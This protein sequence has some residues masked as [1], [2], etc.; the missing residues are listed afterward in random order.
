MATFVAL[1]FVWAAVCSVE[2]L[3]D[4]EFDEEIVEELGDDFVPFGA[5]SAKTKKRKNKLDRSK[6]RKN[7]RLGGKIPEPM[8]VCGHCGEDDNFCLKCDECV[9]CSHSPGQC[10]PEDD[11]ED[12]CGNNC[13]G[14]ETGSCD[15]YVCT[16]GPL[17][18]K[19]GERI[20]FRQQMRQIG[21]LDLFS[22]GT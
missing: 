13:P 21:L 14:V 1:M 12:N 18:G 3:K 20:R 15:E 11:F 4:D 19:A 22:R 9:C 5:S 6:G 17:T 8:L 7:H 2:D 16:C 10:V